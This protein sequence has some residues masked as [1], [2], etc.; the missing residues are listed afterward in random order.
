M[1]TMIC[2]VDAPTAG[3]HA[4]RQKTRQKKKKKRGQRHR[5]KNN[6]NETK[7]RFVCPV[8]GPRTKQETQTKMVKDKGQ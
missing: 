5:A 8:G 2:P 6:T 7:P 3:T 4:I 1:S